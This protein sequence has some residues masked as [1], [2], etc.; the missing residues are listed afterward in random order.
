MKSYSV[1]LLTIIGS[2][3]LPVAGIAQVTF[4]GAQK[5]V[6]YTQTKNNTPASKTKEYSLF[7]FASTSESGQATSFTV[8]TVGQLTLTSSDGQNFAGSNFY[9]TLKDLDKEFP[10][11]DAYTFTAVGGT[12]NGESDS[13]PIN[14]DDFPAQIYLTGTGLTDAKKINPN[15]DFTL[16]LGYAEGAA[17]TGVTISLFDSDGNDVYN[18]TVAAGSTSITIPQSEL[19]SLAADT[20]YTAQITNFNDSDVG[21][22]GA[23]SSAPDSEGWVTSTL[24]KFR[25]K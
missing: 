6:F 20:Y 10:V 18:L 23:F 3:V 11:G 22:T 4:W 2:I 8:S 7:A 14:A 21:S 5:T 16:N 25:V 17:S 19:D 15:A 13:L 12:L 24:F 9:K 1:S